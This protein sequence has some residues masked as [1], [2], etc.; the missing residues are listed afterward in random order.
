MGR[1]LETASE[2]GY[3]D[4]V[5]I[6]AVDF[7]LA[8][9]SIGRAL[10][11]ATKKDHSEI[12]PLLIAGLAQPVLIK[13]PQ[14]KTFSPLEIKEFQKDT[15][16]ISTCLSKAKEIARSHGYSEIVNHLDATAKGMKI[17]I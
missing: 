2:N 6:L 4:A 3:I 10:E 5:K 7:R 13:Y 1:A 17:N 11:K 14:N 8:K 9:Q 15:L 12:L 16:F